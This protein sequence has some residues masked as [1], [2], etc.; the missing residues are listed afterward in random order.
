MLYRLLYVF[1]ISV[2]YDV[3][4][5]T[6]S[7]LYFSKLFHIP[8]NSNKCSDSNFSFIYTNNRSIINS[9]GLWNFN[10]YFSFFSREYY[11][12]SKSNIQNIWFFCLLYRLFKSFC[13][14]CKLFLYKLPSRGLY[15]HFQNVFRRNQ[16]T[17]R[18]LSLSCTKTD[19][20]H[21]LDK[22]HTP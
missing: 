17:P 16:S 19:L 1:N 14:I 18:S 12:T 7:D 11:L 13:F 15:L 3:V 4:F 5:K 22:N 2:C 20:E 6:I 10:W 9:P 8:P 21:D